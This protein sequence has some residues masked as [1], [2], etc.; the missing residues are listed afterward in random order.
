[1]W[2]KSVLCYIYLENHVG[3]LLGGS[4]QDLFIQLAIISCMGLIIEI[5][6]INLNH[7]FPCA[8]TGRW[9]E[10]CYETFIMY[11]LYSNLKLINLKWANN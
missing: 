10:K 11:T 7:Y 9:M 2:K 1:M 6:I 4:A 3:N 8:H 5:R